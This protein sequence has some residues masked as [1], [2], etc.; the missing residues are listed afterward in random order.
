MAPRHA[1]PEQNPNVQTAYHPPNYRGDT[2]GVE[3]RGQSDT[4]G[5]VQNQVEHDV[6]QEIDGKPLWPRIFAEISREN[7]VRDRTN[8]QMQDQAKA[9]TQGVETRPAPMLQ[10]SNYQQYEHEALEDMVK[11]GV[12]PGA[13]GTVGAMWL[14][15]GNRM[16]QFQTDV[17]KAISNSE[18]DWRGQ[19]AESARKFMTDVGNWVGK[20][21]QSAQLAGTQTQ[22]YSAA[23]ETAKNSMPPPVDFNV[24]AA[25]A[26]LRNTTNPF[27]YAVKFGTYM[28][29]YNQQQEAKQQAVQVVGTYDSALGGASTMPAFAPPP[30]MA[31]GGNPPQPPPPEPPP[32]PRP[33]GPGEP[34]GPGGGRVAV[35]GWPW[36]WA[37]WWSWHWSRWH[38][39]GHWWRH[40]FWHWAAAWGWHWHGHW[41]RYWWPGS[42]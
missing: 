10:C 18:A 7:T 28:H 3:M 32:P 26:D 37:R 16:V 5:Q 11:K 4:R 2:H 36:V 14:D 33:P 23:L 24:D 13:V 20:A 6:D 35:L 8:Q 34:G 1:Q 40:R 12:N 27:A 38:R 25:N 41:Y 42:G 30:T 21:G 22:Q 39:W 19:A 9:L 15:A 31:G 29:K 17:V